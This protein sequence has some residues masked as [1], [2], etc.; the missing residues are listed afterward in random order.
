M[1]YFAAAYA[2]LSK[3]LHNFAEN[4][5]GFI[6]EKLYNIIK[7]VV[8]KKFALRGRQLSFC[9]VPLYLVDYVIV[10]L[11]P[12]RMSESPNIPFFRMPKPCIW[13]LCSP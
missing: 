10:A 12:F 4:L 3:L 5:S 13:E 7:V 1:S 8:I 6:Q 11:H 2:A 9:Y